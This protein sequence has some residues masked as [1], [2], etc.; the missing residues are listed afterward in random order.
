MHGDIE[1][2]V[3]EGTG[4]GE[5]CAHT[6]RMLEVIGISPDEARSE[7]RGRVRIR[8]LHHLLPDN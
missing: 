2:S 7:G 8:P 1:T 3:I 5:R 4:D 6:W